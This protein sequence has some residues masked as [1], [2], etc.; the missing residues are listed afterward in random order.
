[1]YAATALGVS[2]GEG[3]PKFRVKFPARP[4][5]DDIVD[6]IAH[7]DIEKVARKTSHRRCARCSK[8]VS[9]R[10]LV[11]RRCGKKQRIN[12]RSAILG[13]AGLFV[14]GLFAVATASQRFPFRARSAQGGSESWSP[15]VVASRD[16]AH[17]TMTAA[18]LW[19]LYNVDNAKADARFKNKDVSVTGTVAD[20]RRNFSGEYT[21]RLATGDSLE[22]VRATIVSHDDTGRSLPVRGQ[23][24]SLRCLGRGKLIGSPVLDSCRPI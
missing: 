3:A 16:P 4:V 18:E 21:L 1:L 6:G 22:T 9:R 11:C 7:S 12:P 20:I 23:V 17:P 14:V 24:V 10:A 8:V 5:E 2:G 19:A 15:F 13:L